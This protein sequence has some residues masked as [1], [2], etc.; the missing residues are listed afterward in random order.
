VSQY[1]VEYE[2]AALAVLNAMPE[3][4]MRQVV[5]RLVAFARNPH[6]PGASRPGRDGLR[7]VTVRG[8]ARAECHINEGTRCVITIRVLRL[9]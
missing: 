2:H 3:T 6:A 9:V 7:V 4:A 5:E 8:I 1:A